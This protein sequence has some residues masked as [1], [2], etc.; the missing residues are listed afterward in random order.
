MIDSNNPDWGDLEL[1]S[2]PTYSKGD[3]INGIVSTKKISIVKDAHRTGTGQQRYSLRP[4]NDS[5]TLVFSPDY[6]TDIRSDPA[7]IP[8]NSDSVDTSVMTGT[9]PSTDLSKL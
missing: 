8:L 2:S 5:N 3:T 6:I 1:P 4:L 7:G 9:L